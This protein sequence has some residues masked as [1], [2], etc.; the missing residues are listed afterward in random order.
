MLFPW[1]TSLYILSVRCVFRLEEY[2]FVLFSVGYCYISSVC[3]WIVVWFWSEG[4]LDWVGLSSLSNGWERMDQWL[5]GSDFGYWGWGGGDWRSEADAGEFEGPGSFQ[6]DPVLCGGGGDRRRW[7]G[8]PPDMDQGR[9]HPQYPRAEQPAREH[10][11]ENLAS[12]S[13]EEAGID[14]FLI[15]LFFLFF[16]FAILKR[17]LIWVRLDVPQWHP[18]IERKWLPLEMGKWNPAPV[19]P[20]FFVGA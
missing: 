7:D 19:V 12:R 16:L 3:I 18:V 9:R 4:E 15:W 5:S 2:P 8:P 6:S 20:P 11:L 10:V 14:C 1:E 17:I 13:P